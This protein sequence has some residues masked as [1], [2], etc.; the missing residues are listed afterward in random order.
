MRT[1][2]SSVYFAGGEPTLRRDLPELTRAARELDYYPIL[3][4]TNASAVDRLLALPRYRTW[5]ADL[6]VVIVSLDGLDTRALTT[7]WG[8]GRPRD[9]LKNLLLLREI[10]AEM[11]IKL[12]VNCV[13]QP[14][15]IR[16]ARD[17]LDF[18]NDLGIWFCPVPMNRGPRIA[19]GLGEDPG[20]R[21]LCDLILARKRD[22]YRVTGSLRLNR[23]LLGAAPLA[24]RNTLKPHVDHDGF[25]YW[26]CKASVNVP[27]ARIDVL[28]FD[29]LASLWS[30]ATRL[31]EPTRFHGPARNQCGAD[32][33]W[34]QN[35]TT[36]A[37]AHGLRRPLSLLRDVGELLSS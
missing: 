34:A 36:D 18:C 8:Y 9:V 17:V 6:D 32:C 4:N 11:R 19:P 2:T 24:C 30:H 26:P 21:A 28:A 12:M 25:L 33:N 31:I 20:Y 7:T 23:R 10:S 16:H 1:G 3:V 29:D 5:L 27:P 15:K 14:G 37:Y 35:Y 22:G 13:I